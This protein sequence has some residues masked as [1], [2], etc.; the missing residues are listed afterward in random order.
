MRILPI[1]FYL[2]SILGDEFK[3]KDEVFEI[4][5][6]VSALTH[7]HKRSKI[8][9]GIYI[10]IASMMTGEK[11]LKTAVVSGINKAVE[12]YKTHSEFNEELNHFEQLKSKDFNKLLEEYLIYWLLV[13]SKSKP[14]PLNWSSKYLSSA[15][16]PFFFG[17]AKFSIQIKKEKSII[18]DYSENTF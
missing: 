16:A 11:D 7:A 17:D 15:Y 5:H 2:Q 12:C 3:G 18:S 14:L 10:P 4:I 9:C 1:L 13:T 8:A 6:N